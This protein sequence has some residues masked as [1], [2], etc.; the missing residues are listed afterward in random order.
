MQQNDHLGQGTQVGHGPKLV[1]WLR[2][3][4]C[5]GLT[6]LAM[7]SLVSACK[8]IAAKLG[9][10]TI[11]TAAY[12][13]SD[14]RSENADKFKP[15][16][17]FDANNPVEFGMAQAIYEGDEDRVLAYLDSGK[18]DINHQGKS[19]F[20]YVTYAAYV[21]RFEVLKILLEHGADPNQ[22]STVAHTQLNFSDEDL[23]PLFIVCRSAW[24]PKEYIELLLDHGADMYEERVLSPF[25]LTIASSKEA[26]KKMQVFI[27]RGI[28]LNR[29]FSGYSPI[30]YT[31]I[32][33]RIDLIERFMDL[34]VD[35]FLAKDG[36]HSLAFQMQEIVD[37]GLGDAEYIACAKSVM[38]RLEKLGVQ[39]P[40]SK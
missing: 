17:Y 28:E 22:F 30:F 20:H 29:L 10:L 33:R 14:K 9:L 2:K 8:P 4:V 7:V 37:K 32:C 18:V 3:F 35:P 31:V 1:S 36:D 27:D 26:P 21:E 25:L 23:T 34:G 38:Q 24:Y 39:F 15:E 12:S 19:G 16:M 5:I 6:L 13:L 40:V 11:E